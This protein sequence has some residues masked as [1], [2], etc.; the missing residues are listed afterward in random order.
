MRVAWS[1]QRRKAP[2]NC[3]GG[4]DT[5]LGKAIKKKRLKRTQPQ[6]RMLESRLRPATK[7]QQASFADAPPAFALNVWNRD[8]NQPLLGHNRT[9]W[10]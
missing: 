5:A 4:L 10:D 7:S 2:S 6:F 8:A 3:S 1:T 9:F